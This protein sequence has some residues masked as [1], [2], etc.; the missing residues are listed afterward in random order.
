MRVLGVSTITKGKKVTLVR[1]VTDILDV[2]EGD[3]IVFY[4]NDGKVLIEKK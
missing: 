3:E 2:N 1:D 4:E